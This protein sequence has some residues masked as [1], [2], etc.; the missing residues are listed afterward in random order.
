MIDWMRVTELRTEIGAE[1]F[2]EVV[3]LFLEEVDAGMAELGSDPDHL[4]EQLHALKG[5]ALNLGFSDFAALCQAGETR[6][7]S[8][9]GDID[10]DALRAT[11]DVSM[12]AF[13]E[14]LAARYAA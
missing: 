12:T 13:L 14:G 6:A 1:D 10:L 8:G 5:S 9:Q 3:D 2:T 7:A 11:Y 4:E